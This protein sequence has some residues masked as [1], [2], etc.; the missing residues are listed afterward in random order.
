MVAQTEF[1][2]LLISL[3]RMGVQKAIQQTSTQFTPIHA[4]ETLVVPTLEEIGAGWENGTISLSQ[5]YMCG[6][7]CEE[8]LDEIL[9]P[10]DASRITQP[11]M[12]I[13]VLDDFHMLGKRIVY[14]LLRS[15]GYDLLNYDHMDIDTLIRQ[16]QKDHI[17]ILLISV[18]MLPSALHIKELRRLLD[19]LKYPLKII[20]GG[21]P[22]RF[23]DQL[24]KEVGADAAG[25][26]AAD[27][28]SLVE[29]MIKEVK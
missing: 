12:A 29:Q 14:S 13:V 20:V 18:L 22:F 8:M 21:A 15:S 2:E 17:K 26:N 1:K 3:N 5:V 28:V 6:K 24:W 7:I 23:D 11:P 9:P 19:G 27:A 4:I 10:G 25:R 16:I